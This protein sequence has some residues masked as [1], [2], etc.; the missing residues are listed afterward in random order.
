[1]F[2]SCGFILEQKKHF[3]YQGV[4]DSLPPSWKGATWQVGPITDR[5]KWRRTWGPLQNGPN[6]KMGFC[7]V[8]STLCGR[9]VIWKSITGVLGPPCTTVEGLISGGERPI[10]A[11]VPLLALWKCQPD[12]TSQRISSLKSSLLDE[13]QLNLTSIV[14]AIPKFQLFCMASS[15]FW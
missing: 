12:F 15:P 2:S 11:T 10:S 3:E 8:I 4:Q 7:E 5:Y 13:H 1:M 6:K 14:W 9:G